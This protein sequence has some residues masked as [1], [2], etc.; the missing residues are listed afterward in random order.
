MLRVAILGVGWAGTRHVRAIRELVNSGRRDD[1]LVDC[2][3]DNDVEFLQ[4]K[5]AVLGIEKTYPDYQAALND[6]VVNAVSICLPHR[7]HC[8]VAIEA[9]RAGKHVLVEKPMALTVADA[10]RMIEAA[11]SQGVALYVAENESYSAASCML[12]EIVQTG[13]YIGELTGAALA[14][15]FRAPDYGY[16]GRR[17]WLSTPEL[18][19]TGHWMLQGVHSMAQLR[20]ILGEVAIVYL[21]EHKASSFR[22]QDVEGTLSGLLTLGSGLHVSIL[23]TAETRLAHSL[24]GYT[25]YGDQGVV[26]SGREGIEVFS[27]VLDPDERPVCLPYPAVSLSPYAAEMDAFADYVEGRRAGPTTGRS[28][29]R[30]LAIIEAG[31][32]SLESG[33]PVNLRVQF[34]DLG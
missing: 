5:A 34:G 4:K 17:A 10:T 12:R 28:E 23:Q 9:V 29:R 30:S 27:Q 32:A 1:I 8:P 13:R 19:G 3:V 6:S 20:F 25:L 21:R 18:G 14:R 11:E 7:L 15:G 33:A 22:R 31:Y 26:R 16:S 2:L 24:R